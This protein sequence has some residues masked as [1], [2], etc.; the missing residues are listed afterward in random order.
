MKR[1]LSLIGAIL[2]VV[3]AVQSPI[4]TAFAA[5]ANLVANASFEDATSGS[6]TGWL[7]DNW[8]TNTTAYTY[9][10]T[11]HTGSHSATVKMSNYTSGD[12]KWYF[13]PVT[14][15]PGT[16]YTFSDWYKSGIKNSI[17]AV[18]TTTAGKTQY[19]WQGDFAASTDWKQASFSFKA[20]TGAKS[21]TFFHYIQAN[22]SLTV[23]DY[24]FGTG[25]PTTPPVTP[26]PPVATAPTVQLTAPTTGATVSGTQTITATASD[27]VG[28]TS[29][30]FKLDGT[31]LGAADTTA[32]YSTTWD[33]KTATN[34][35]HTLTAV[36]TNAA[37][38][39]TT[40]TAA[41][42]TVNNPTPP[43]V[44]LS[45]P[46]NNATVS[47]TQ[48][49]TAAASDAQGITSVQFK[50]DGVNLGSALTTAP[51]TYN[52]D[53]TK[54]TNGAHKLTAVATNQANLST[55]STEVAVTVN[56]VVVTPPVTPPATNL[57]L[58]PSVETLTSGLPTNWRADGWGTNTHTTTVE[59]TG[60][61]GSH[62]VKTTMS[63]YTNGDAKWYFD[64]IA[65]TPGAQYQYS[66]WY[67]SS[68][69]SEV[70]AQVTMT[71][72]TVQYFYLA[73]A[74]ASPSAWAQVKA[75][76]TAPA[77][78]K[79]ITI[80][81]ALTKV[82]FVQTDDFSFAPYA[83]A[84]F[85]RAMV[86]LTFDDAWK[87]IE[88]NGLPLLKKYNMVA[89]GYMLTQ[90]TIDGYPDYMTL[91]EMTAWKSAGNEVAAHTMTHPDLTTLTVAQI[92]AELSGSQNQLRSWFGTPGVANNFATP[93]GAY[94][95]SVIT[96]IK[97]FYR[98]HRS[99][100]VG[101]NSKDSFDIYNIKVQNVENTTTPAMVQAW[102]NQAIANKTWLVLVYHEVDPAAADP[103]YA[104][105]PANLDAELN[106]IK[107]SGVTVETVDQAL[108]EI[109]PQ[110]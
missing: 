30:Q 98:S 5:D 75:Q 41:T 70:D 33:T 85:N 89:T 94:N 14:V 4:A 10:N 55:T 35:T 8:G 77:G 59:N 17:D 49:I 87:T 96:E 91:A 101:F 71:D 103:T 63:A 83:P 80:F 54:V 36:A 104:V 74:S 64:D 92:D 25:T 95:S 57:V 105:T 76:F 22:G 1:V 20:P 37:N 66:N 106:N 108:N 21:V 16:T 23:D 72:G 100:D 60:H 32:P 7:K 81:Q 24:S 48:A 38:L 107:Q 45:A 39:T 52:W 2:V 69:D 13:S 56:N 53:T 88:T 19:K 78:A 40:S 84:Q 68:V 44:Q 6:P 47:G 90:P 18:I 110:L 86:S 62:S 67:E 65:I 97:K 73:T 51:Y 61:T 3:A 28:V 15:T 9:E 43:T 34:G 109:Q 79:S 27:A 82:G 12:A 58:N 31:N 11:G 26:V 46:A 42:V 50:L 93:Y 29:V 102:V 99:T